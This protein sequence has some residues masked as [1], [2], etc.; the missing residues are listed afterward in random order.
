MT[1]IAQII[2]KLNEHPAVSLFAALGVLGAIYAIASRR[3]AT[4]K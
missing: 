1:V 4:R 3:Q 2:V